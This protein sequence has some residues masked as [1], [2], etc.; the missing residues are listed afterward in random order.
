MGAQPLT[1][2]PFSTILPFLAR[3]MSNI[4]LTKKLEG[5]EFYKHVLGSSKY[6]IAPMVDQS[7]LVSRR[8][9]YS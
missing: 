9:F 7:E 3:A 2:F 1:P 4:P 5:Y 8:H 6:I